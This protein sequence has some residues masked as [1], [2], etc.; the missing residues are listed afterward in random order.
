MFP[1]I[2]GHNRIQEVLL[3]MLEQGTLPHAL[4]FVGSQGLGKTTMA[5]AL[6]RHLLGSS[7]Q[8]QNHPDY[9]EVHRLVDEKTEKRKTSISVK[10]I[11]EVT[12]RL[13]LTS[14]SGGWKIVFFEQ[15]QFLS[16]GAAN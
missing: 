8:V 12:A 11:R 13:G 5:Q 2:I 3:R 9:Q 16:Q 1:S 15:A 6:I 4:L 10:Q 7:T 14:L